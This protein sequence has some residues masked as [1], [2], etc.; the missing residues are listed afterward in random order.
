MTIEAASLIIEA[1]KSYPPSYLP[2]LKVKKAT[3]LNLLYFRHP[4]VMSPE[5]SMTLANKRPEF[6]H[7]GYF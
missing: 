1:M 2:H 5:L 4:D 6:G 7:C 3:S